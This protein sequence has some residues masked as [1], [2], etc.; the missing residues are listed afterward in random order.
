[1]TE[2][3]QTKPLKI[4]LGERVHTADG[5]LPRERRRVAIEH[6]CQVCGRS[7]GAHR[8][9]PDLM[10][11]VLVCVSPPLDGWVRPGFVRVETHGGESSQWAVGLREDADMRAV[12]GDYELIDSSGSSE[13]GRHCSVRR[14]GS[15]AAEWSRTLPPAVLRAAVELAGL[16]F[17]RVVRC[18][19]R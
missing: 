8:T 13:T 11:G 18:L 9:E 12:L 7:L 3:T 16:E 15:I 2:T 19:S 10:A 17:E 4:T 5:V 6:E 14:D 1:M